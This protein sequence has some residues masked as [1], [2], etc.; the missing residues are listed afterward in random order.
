MLR[1]TCASVLL[2][3]TASAV[4]APLTTPLRL[5]PAPTGELTPAAA[6]DPAR[7]YGWVTPPDSVFSESRFTQLRP[8]E[9]TDGVAGRD[10]TLRLDLAPGR[11]EAIVGLDDG[12]SNAADVRLA[13]N[14]RVIAHS[15]RRFGTSSEP[16]APPIDRL[17]VARF[18]FDAA[19]PVFLR[20]SA[21][22]AGARLVSLEII[23]LDWPET[24]LTRWLLRQIEETG[25]Y[26]STAPLDALRVQ[27]NQHAQ[28]EPALAGFAAHWLARIELLDRAEF[29]FRSGGWD[30]VSARTRSSMFTRYHLVLSLLDPLIDSSDDPH[31][32]LR[33]RA[34]WLRARLLYGLWLEQGAAEDKAA[35]DADIAV[36]RRDHPDD[37]LVAMYAGEK[38]S[39]PLPADAPAPLSGAPAWSTTQL[40]V[41]ARLR[42]L[43]R[44]WTDERQI[45][46]GELGGKLDDDVE[47][48]RWWTPL[49]LT[50]D[51]RALAGFRRL[52]EAVWHSP[53]IHNGYSRAARDVEHSAEFIS[54]T[55]PILSLATADRE[56]I[57]R[58]SWSYRHMRDLWTGRND[59]GDL[60]FKSA[61]IGAT[62][63]LSDPPR[64]RDL[65]MNTR[66]A[67][68]VRYYARLAPAP[69]AARLLQDWSLTWAK[70]AARTDK[71]KPRGLFPASL[72]W[73]D[74]ALNGDEPDWYRANMFW[75]YFDWSGQGDLYDQLLFSWNDSHNP[76]LLEPMRDTLA[77]LEQNPNPAADA[78]P[79]S[80]AWAAH[81]LLESPSFW[82]AVIHWRLETGDTRFDSFLVRHAP[83]YLRYRLSGDASALASG[84]ESTLLTVLRYNRPLLTTE[85]LFTDRVYVSTDSGNYLGTDLLT[86]MLTGC[87]AAD[88]RSPWFHVAWENTPPTFTALVTDT[89]SDRLAVDLFLHQKKSATVTVRLLRLTPGAYR[90][91]VESNGRVLA[92]RTET[93]SDAQ[94]RLNVELP[95]ATPVT[96]RLT[97]VK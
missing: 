84:L 80:A 75:D 17:R 7:G 95:G 88:G 71:G 63:I 31:P 66:A 72:R 67:K 53:R 5:D 45:P 21:P 12:Y 54:D 47:I 24:E 19:D 4:A 39:A 40:E 8:V 30:W 77:L 93:V 78:A 74:A 73:P 1:F 70:T 9:L 92:D 69:D 61:W 6:Y 15:P 49:V 55:L 68:A 44:Y 96:L 42:D 11:W 52:A 13:V 60:Q 46:N 57:E 48:L 94:R 16:P 34:R 64:N 28:R 2:F 41:L 50:G 59:R 97:P 65:A 58:L 43:A 79:G 29:W 62:E 90:V 23:P 76:A 35:F 3:A 56:W 85:A 87:H 82:G 20:F 36:L 10:Y 14:D 83:P 37:S 22:D 38:I 51:T 91:T 26:H 27:L 81:A 89:A 86:A 33:D 32:A 25:R 18:S